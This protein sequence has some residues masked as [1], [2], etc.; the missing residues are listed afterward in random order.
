VQLLVETGPL[1]GTDKAIV[2]FYDEKTVREICAAPNENSSSLLHSGLAPPGID[3]TGHAF[4]SFRARRRCAS[5]LPS[6]VNVTRRSY[7]TDVRKELCGNMKKF[8]TRATRMADDE[9]L[10][11]PS[12]EI[13]YSHQ[14]IPRLCGCRWLSQRRSARIIRLLF[15]LLCCVRSHEFHR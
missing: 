9:F 11:D 3:S 7:V 15:Q 4:S 12:V 14:E 1:W 2:S 13:F 8:T 10:W 5:R 6:T